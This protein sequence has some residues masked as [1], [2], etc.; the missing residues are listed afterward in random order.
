MRSVVES[1]VLSGPYAQNP[2]ANAL[3][4]DTVYNFR[5]ECTAA[6]VMGVATLGLFKPGATTAPVTAAAVV[7][8]R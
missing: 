7:P 4:W 5:F 3:R 1:P 2:D 6:P 8:G